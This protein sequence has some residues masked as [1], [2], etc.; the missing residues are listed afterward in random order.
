MRLDFEATQCVLGFA[1]ACEPG[2]EDFRADT[3]T[4]GGGFFELAQVGG[5]AG[6][7]EVKNW[8]LVD[9]CFDQA[10]VFSG[11][12]QFG[13]SLAGGFKLG[14]HFGCDWL[15]RGFNHL[16]GLRSGRC[17]RWC[18]GWSSGGCCRW[19]GGWGSGLGGIFLRFLGRKSQG[20]VGGKDRQEQSKGKASHGV[21]SLVRNRA[22]GSGI[23]GG[24]INLGA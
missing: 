4:V 2:A 19:C 11:H 14:F 8:R 12:N 24:R 13:H 17:S 7:E 15:Q 21:H 9:R 10:G 1:L 18:G 22:F 23:L 20:R 6:D 16:L 3:D 5:P